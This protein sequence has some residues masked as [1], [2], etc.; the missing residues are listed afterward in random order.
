MFPSVSSVLGHHQV[1]QFLESA[2]EMGFEGEV[3]VEEYDCPFWMGGC[4]QVRNVADGCLTLEGCFTWDNGV[5]QHALVKVK[6]AVASTV[7][8]ATGSS[9]STAL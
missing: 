7:L 4:K 3:K 8:P 5:K 9:T 2:R 1:K 6:N